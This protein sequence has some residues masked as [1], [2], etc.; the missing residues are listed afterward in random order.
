MA[1]AR[2]VTVSLGMFGS[3][4]SFKVLNTFE[5]ATRFAGGRLRPVAL[6]S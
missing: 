4:V 2:L 5:P 6:G 1:A 3:H